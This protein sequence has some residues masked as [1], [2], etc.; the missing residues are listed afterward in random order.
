MAIVAMQADRVHPDAISPVENMAGS[1]CFQ[2]AALV[3]NPDGE[4]IGPG[5][6]YVCR[7]GLKVMIPPNWIIEVYPRRAQDLTSM[8]RLGCRV[9]LLD[10]SFTDEVMVELVNESKEVVRVMHGDLIADGILTQVHGARFIDMARATAEH[11]P[12]NPGLP[13]PL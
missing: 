10:N 12:E 13:N 2:F 5:G 11:A 4:Y 6:T 8:N 7:T 3:E 1:A 9:G